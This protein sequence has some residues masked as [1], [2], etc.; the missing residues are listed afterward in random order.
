[1]EKVLG[2]VGLLLQL[3]NHWCFAWYL[4]VYDGR[5]MVG[6]QCNVICGLQ[7]SRHGSCK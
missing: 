2:V 7:S 6:N 4:F 1:M 3:S 5:L